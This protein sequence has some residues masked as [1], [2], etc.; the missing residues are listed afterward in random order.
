[1]RRESPTALVGALDAEDL[2]SALTDGLSVVGDLVRQVA[3][4]N[5]VSERA[6]LRSMGVEPGND[7]D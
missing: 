4:H 7:R 1:M 3:E 5:L 6:V 2:R